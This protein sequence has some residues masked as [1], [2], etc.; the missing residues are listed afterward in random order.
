MNELKVDGLTVL[1]VEDDEQICENLAELFELRGFRSVTAYDGATGLEKILVEKPNVV[2]CDIKM[3]GMSGMELLKKVREN[4]D[5]VNLPFV[6]LTAKIEHQDLREGMEN[7]ADDYLF[8]PARFEDL[9]KATI[10]RVTRSL[11]I[12]KQKWPEL[13]IPGQA[14]NRQ[15]IEDLM[16]VLSQREFEIFQLIMSQ[17]S[18]KE[19]ADTLHVSKKTVDNH[20][21]NIMQKLNIHGNNAL[22]K[23]TMKLQAGV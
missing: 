20:R 1:I 12:A 4:D 7:G 19:I 14:G 22:L 9:Y 8:K 18:T 23:F 15:K 13:S 5:F 11:K 16:Q 3:P 21:Y 10:T 17:K 6:F 2:I